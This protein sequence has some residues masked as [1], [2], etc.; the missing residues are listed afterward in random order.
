MKARA[1]ILLLLTPPLLFS[2]ILIRQLAGRAVRDALCDR[3]AEAAGAAARLELWR[4]APAFASGREERILPVLYT[5]ARELRAGQAA[6]ADDSGRILAHT[7][8]AR[9][10]R[11]LDR[12][13]DWPGAGASPSYYLS[14]TGEEGLLHVLVPLEPPRENSSEELALG[15]QAAARTLGTLQ[16][17]LPLEDILKSEKDI[18]SRITVILGAVFSAILLA[19]YLLTGLALRPVR[20]LIEGTRMISR[21][22]YGALIPVPSGDEFGDLAASF[23]EMSAAL[24]STIVSKDYL[25]AI[26]ENISDILLV[27]DGD[28]HVQRTNKAARDA[29]GRTEA[30]LAGR[31]LSALFSCGAGW[32]GGLR[33]DGRL[34]EAESALLTPSG[35]LPVLVSAARI[36]EAGGYAVLA[37]DIA[38]RKKYE[39]ELAR[40]NED[41]RRFAFVASHDLQE[42]L[43]TITT[44]I[45]LLE[46]RYS[47]L[48]APEAAGHV[49]FV[50]GAIRRMRGLVS[51]LLDYSKLD[52]E[53]NLVRVDSGAALA[54]AKELMKDS[55]SS[56]G[57]AVE[58]GPLPEVLAGRGHLERLFQNLISNSVKFRGQTAPRIRV[59]A[60][61]LDGE[62]V[63]SVKDNGEGIDPK[64]EPKLFKL[65]GRLHGASVE[66]AGIGLAACKKIVELH[67]WKIWFES[68]PG[69]GAVFS[70][71]LPDPPAKTIQR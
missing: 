43:R 59:E 70:F 44:Y 20:L 66:G 32:L 68:R 67:G 38:M 7:D 41:L 26:V 22:R 18:V 3:A 25:D 10:G 52:A 71:T 50:T 69:E 33:A 42:P 9:R 6:F 17:S 29:L 30:E 36:A 46:A 40:S 48:L 63:F 53:L 57:A 28:G 65:F 11:P 5:I 51:G 62:W 45:Q 56:S 49:S 58:N 2:A 16:V 8:V 21:G 47:K 1:K 15:G 34:K 27:T 14:G 24:A 31:P 19:A 35:E 39:G 23:N 55:L 61:R 54:A 64:Y 37:R 60:A 4:S 12:R 13:A